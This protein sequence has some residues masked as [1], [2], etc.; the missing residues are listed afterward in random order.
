M[1]CRNCGNNV[2]EN[3]FA[4]T[5]CGCRPIDGKNF[6]N[7]CGKETQDKQVICINCGVS[8]ISRP[9][10]KKIAAGLLG[11]L[12]GCFGVHKFYLGYT[13]QGVIMLLIS[14]LSIFVLAAIPAIIGLIEGILY[15]TMDDIEFET[16]YITGHKPWF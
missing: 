6:C 3:A 9:S 4:C 12:L 16:T 1:Y 2:E 5:K 13:T 8:L 14:I 11:I 10:R 15:L 7:N